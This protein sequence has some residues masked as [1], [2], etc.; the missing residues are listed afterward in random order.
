[1]L[2]R[3]M[4]VVS[5]AGAALVAPA[6]AQ[7]DAAA[8]AKLEAS[9]EAIKNAKSLQF[10][11]VQKGEGGV[12]AGFTPKIS[13]SIV[14]ERVAGRKDLWKTR[15]SGK[16][17]AMLNMPE[18]PFLVVSD[19]E[20][21]TWAD[22][23]TKTFYERLNAAASGEMVDLS[24]QVLLPDLVAG[25]PFAKDLGA[26]KIS[27]EAPGE[28]DGVAC[29]VIV[30]EPEKEQ[31]PK[32]RWSIGQADRIPR[33]LES[34]FR[35][36]GLNDARVWQLSNVKLDQPVPEGSFAISRPEGYTLSGIENPAAPRPQA[37]PDTAAPAQPNGQPAAQ[38]PA[39]AARERAIGPNVGDLAPDFELKQSD[40]SMLKLS[41][42]RGKVVLLDFWGTWCL[43][44]RK[45]SPIVQSIHE[46]YKNEPVRVLAPAAR[47]RN[48]DAPFKY[49]AENKYTYTALLQQSE[50]VSKAFRVAVYPTF[51]VIGADGVIASKLTLGD[52][53]GVEELP[54]RMRDEIDK[55][56]A[57]S[58]PAQR[59]AAES[60]KK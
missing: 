4:I 50:E 52:V 38:P 43:P 29:D 31:E 55:A 30:V 35:S 6:L 12:L 60:E 21:T 28:V 32:S 33:K 48:P 5:L 9:A 44:C 15:S 47:E 10:D 37:A 26:P 8:K 20:R 2:A 41:S 17:A 13:A 23:R 36:G 14:L 25:E 1:M 45:T 3:T 39:P 56:L 51:I 22:E 54:A 57:N 11:I 7:V 40:G 53:G 49:M 24:R 34:I 46:A 19:G 16:M 18:M 59:P 42:L 27:M 58:K